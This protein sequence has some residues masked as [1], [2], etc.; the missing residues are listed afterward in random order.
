M[1]WHP[2]ILAKLALIPERTMGSCS[3]LPEGKPGDDCLYQAGDFVVHLVGCD[4]NGG[5]E[6]Q[7]E[8]ERFYKIWVEK[9]ERMIE[10]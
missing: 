5:E 10:S 8:M 6:C 1:Q 7:E 3:A 2:T 4:K 9:I